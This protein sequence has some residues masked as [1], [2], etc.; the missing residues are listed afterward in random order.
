[1]ISDVLREAIADIRSYQAREPN[2]YAADF[3]RID[4]FVSHAVTLLRHLDAPPRE[5]ANADARAACYQATD[6][7]AAD[8]LYT[9]R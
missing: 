5:A 7:A 2:A 8:C 9:A 6:A 4:A 1:M 3:A